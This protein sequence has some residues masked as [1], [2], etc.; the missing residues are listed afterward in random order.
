[1][2][3]FS[4]NA[5]R[6]QASRGDSRTRDIGAEW[7]HIQVTTVDIVAARM[8]TPHIRHPRHEYTYIQAVSRTVHSACRASGI[9]DGKNAA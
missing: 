8:Y 4:W 9:G 7:E 2:S 5:T 3:Q 1:M 6:S